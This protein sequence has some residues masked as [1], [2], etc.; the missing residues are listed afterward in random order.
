MSEQYTTDAPSTSTRYAIAIHG[1]LRRV[2]E[3]LASPISKF[4]PSITS[5]NRISAC[6]A[7]S[8]T[9]KYGERCCAENTASRCMSRWRAKISTS[10]PSRYIGAKNGRPW[11]WSQWVWLIRIDA[12]PLPSPNASSI[13]DFPRRRSPVPA[14]MMIGDPPRGLTSTHEVFPPYRLVV[15][16][17]TGI[18]PRT[19]QNLTFI[20]RRRGQT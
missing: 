4:A 5:W 19:P 13:R 8:G 17:G 2:H 1:W 12:L 18:D 7:D 10:F 11:T 16:P 6:I 15:R 3:T 20:V 14:S 9:G